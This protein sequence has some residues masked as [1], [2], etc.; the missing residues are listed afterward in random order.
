MDNP[1]PPEYAAV[2]HLLT[3]PTVEARCRPYIGADDVDWLGLLAE[4]ETMSGG[5]QVLIRL[6]YDL[7]QAEGVIGVWELPRR[8]DRTHFERALEA[9]S[10]CR[11]ERAEAEAELRRAAA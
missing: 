7:W 2:R 8:L 9:L 10:L 5:A 11:G 4:A 3:M 1:L 6:A